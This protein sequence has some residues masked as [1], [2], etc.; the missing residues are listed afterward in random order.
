MSLFAGPVLYSTGT[1]TD[2]AVGSSGTRVMIRSV[3]VTA[4]ATATTVNI[5][6]G[7]AAEDQ[8]VFTLAV[9]A[10]TNFHLFLGDD[11]MTFADGCFVDVDANTARATVGY[12]VY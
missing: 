1:T 2:F 7:D 8:A 5:R 3:T 10:S 4:S 6:N 12:R 9:A 11:G